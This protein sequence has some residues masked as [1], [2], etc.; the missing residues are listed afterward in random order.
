MK[1]FI[2][3]IYIF[4]IMLAFGLGMDCIK[5]NN[6]SPSVGT[7]SCTYRSDNTQGN[8]KLTNIENKKWIIDY[9]GT[10]KELTETELR[11]KAFPTKNCEDI[12]YIESSGDIFVNLTANIKKTLE[13][14]CTNHNESDI[15]Y[16]CPVGS[17]KSCSSMDI[18]CDLNHNET[19][20]CDLKDIPIQLPIFI[21]RLINLFK[22]IAPIILVITGLIDF[23]RAVIASDEKQMKESQNRFIRRIVAAVFIFFI[24]A[25]VQ[26]VINAIS[27]DGT[28]LGCFDC[29]ISGNC[30]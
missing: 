2:Y 24:I 5:A 21:S 22:I 26:F 23:L 13:R 19:E 20:K 1:K 6:I 17:G 3:F 10:T 28:I 12:L 11:G 15:K 25:I 27:K 16:F 29:F 30:E 7:Y 18:T 8:L 14:A 9:N 4:I